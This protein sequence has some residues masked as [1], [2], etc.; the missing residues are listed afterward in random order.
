LGFVSGEVVLLFI[1]N[2]FKR[3]GLDLAIDTIA[4]ERDLLS[5]IRLFVV[6]KG[7]VSMFK[8]RAKRRGVRDRVLFVGP[9][10]KVEKYYAAADI[11][12][13][14][15][16][17]DPFAVVCLEAMACGLPVITT[18]MNGAAELIKD[19]SSGF[20]IDSKDQL[21]DRIQL[22]V[23]P[24]KR[25]D[26]GALAAAQARNFSEENHIDSLL[27]VLSKISEQRKMQE[28]L[29]IVRSNS[30]LVINKTF[31]ELLEANNL[32]KYENLTKTEQGTPIDYNISK[33]IFLFRL[34]HEGQPITLYL[35]R[36]HSHCG[37]GE[38]FGRLTR[39]QMI[40]EGMKEWRNV[41]ALQAHGLP[42]LTPVAAGGRVLS[43]GVK[44]SFFMSLGLDGYNPLD[45]Y[46]STHFTPPMDQKKL[47]AKRDLLR[48]VARLT[49]NLHGT[50]FNHRDFYL[51]HLFVKAKEPNDFDLRIIDLQRVG[52]QMPFKRRWLVKD[53][54]SL[55][56]SSLDIP[57]SDWD[58]FR[59]Y[60][61]YS[62]GWMDRT[63]R[64]SILRKVIKKSRDIERHDVKLRSNLNTS[65]DSIR[66][67]KS[68]S[69]DVV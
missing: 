58:R 67:R 53:L 33:R 34:R 9:E 64:R 48:A 38:W 42:T 36:Y 63:R 51:C 43:G 1:S 4:A 37:V 40:T 39:K 3:K 19:G 56:Y 20:L 23:D 55:H 49:Q 27:G 50:G 8:W 22:L 47:K 65:H 21:A 62:S 12:V 68:E 10:E 59:F 61:L 44:E 7:R 6:G 26:M 54:A 2:N 24:K 11:F 18:R 13:L 52:F 16:R 35:K 69:Q 32:A 29:P 25:A 17:Y 30:D 46:I 31:G 15:T 45:S 41:L 57:L 66:T 14:P 28:N 60:V 5:K